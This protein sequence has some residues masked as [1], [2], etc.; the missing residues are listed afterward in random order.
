MANNIVFKVHAKATYT[1]QPLDGFGGQ[2]QTISLDSLRA[3]IGEVE[4]VTGILDNPLISV[5]HTGLTYE[6]EEN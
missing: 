1:E 2:K 4:D 6:Y 3:F 5:D